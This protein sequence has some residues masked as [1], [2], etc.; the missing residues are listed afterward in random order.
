MALWVTHSPRNT[1]DVGSNP[2]IGRSIVARTTTQNG[3]PLSLDL[4]LSSRVKNLKDVDKWLSL[5]LCL[6]V[7]GVSVIYPLDCTCAVRWVI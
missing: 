4:N 1:E 7:R 5:S 2:G 6:S 3:G